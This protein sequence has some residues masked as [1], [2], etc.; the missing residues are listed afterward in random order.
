M[1]YTGWLYAFG[2]DY[3]ERERDL[4]AIYALAPNMPALLDK[5]NVEYVVIGPGEIQSFKPDV[6]AFRARYQ[7][8]ISTGSYEIFKVR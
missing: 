1:S 6:A 2:I 4:R 3:G 5:Y 7:R 8:I